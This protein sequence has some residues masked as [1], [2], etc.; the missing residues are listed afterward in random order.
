TALDPDDAP[1]AEDAYQVL[2]RAGAH[3]VL[4]FPPPCRRRFEMRLR[5]PW[6][7]E[8]SAYWIAREGSAVVGYLQVDLPTLENLENASVEAVVPPELR[9]RGLGRALY[10]HAVAFVR[11]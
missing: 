10:D 2:L 9:R 8:R 6:P 4:D 3:D 11:A 7:G 5:A 1:A